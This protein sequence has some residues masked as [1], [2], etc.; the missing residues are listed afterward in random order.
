LQ[1]ELLIDVLSKRKQLKSPMSM[2]SELSSISYAQAE[3]SNPMVQN[4][5]ASPHIRC[6][7]VCFFQT[8][9]IM[10]YRVLLRQCSLFFELSTY[11][12]TWTEIRRV[13]YLALF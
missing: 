1:D 2:A 6:L 13:T 3:L 5:P 8:W 10:T 4:R 9:C 7:F 12:L 11:L